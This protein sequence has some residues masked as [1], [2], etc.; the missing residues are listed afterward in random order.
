MADGDHMK[1][2]ARE[3][4]SAIEAGDMERFA[5]CFTPDAELEIIGS[6]AIAGRKPLAAAVREVSTL[7]KL[8]PGGMKFR[9][10]SITWEGHRVLVELRGM[11]KLSNGAEYFNRY[12]FVL[13]FNK[14]GKIE[15]LREY[16]DTLLVERVLM[17]AF[18][19]FM[20]SSK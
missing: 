20:A 2:V 18:Q 14:D 16:Q 3:Y 12:V 4:V 6:L 17:P 11:N 19:E 15:E 1:K 10:E 7:K 9:E 8:F 13:E 5:A